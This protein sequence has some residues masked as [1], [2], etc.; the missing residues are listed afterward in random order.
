PDLCRTFGRAR[1]GDAPPGDRS[2]AVVPTER[3]GERLR[4]R[5]R[6]GP[7]RRSGG[8]RREPPDRRARPLVRFLRG[9][10]E[11]APR[12]P[13]PRS[14]LRPRSGLKIGRASCRE[15]VKMSGGGGSWK[16]KE[17]REER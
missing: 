7:R 4:S 1:Q 15:R 2:G 17:E 12:A 14:G 13:L 16:R 6:G 9:G 3:S 10:S 8:G 5:R 11:R